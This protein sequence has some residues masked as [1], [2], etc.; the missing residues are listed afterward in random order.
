MSLVHGS[1][2]T[3]VNH[4]CRCAACT[5]ANT[6]YLRKYRERRFGT[7]S[8]DDN[9]HGLASTYINYGCRCGPCKAAKA[10]YDKRYLAKKKEA[11]R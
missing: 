4:G 3:Y 2:S 5:K 7:L 10:A 8:P 6:E 9:R 11:T 1:H